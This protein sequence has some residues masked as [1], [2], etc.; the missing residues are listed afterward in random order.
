MRV[1]VREVVAVGVRL[2]ISG[3]GVGSGI[4]G[5]VGGEVGDEVGDSRL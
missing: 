5:K 2:E 3:D 1:D 4:S